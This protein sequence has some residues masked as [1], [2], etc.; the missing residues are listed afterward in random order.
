[1]NNNAYAESENE[2]F[3]KIYPK[4]HVFYVLVHIRTVL[5]FIDVKH[6]ILT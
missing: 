4:Y 3:V 1:L 2:C 6:Y 5:Y